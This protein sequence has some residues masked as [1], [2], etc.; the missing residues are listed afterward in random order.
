MP[1]GKPHYGDVLR[2]TIHSNSEPSKFA[3]VTVRAGRRYSLSALVHH[4]NI[5]DL[6]PPET[7]DHSIF[8][9]DSN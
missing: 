4:E 5:A 1:T 8:R 7:W 2:L 3:E 9:S 6:K